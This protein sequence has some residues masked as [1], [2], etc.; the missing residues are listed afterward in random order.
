MIYRCKSC[1]LEEARGCLPTASCALYL[2]GLIGL[3][4]FVIGLAIPLFRRAWFHDAG[5]AETST[6]GWAWLLIIPAAVGAAVLIAAALDKIFALAEW[7]LF[8]GRRCPGCGSR[9]WSRGFTRGFGL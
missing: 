8:A 6:P 9:R 3:A 7:L 2:L 5:A 4:A 1:G